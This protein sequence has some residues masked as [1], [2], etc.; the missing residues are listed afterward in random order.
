MSDDAEFSVAEQPDRGRYELTRSDELISYALYEREGD[1]VA[2]P[3]VET[4]PDLRGHGMADRLMEG[5]LADLRA[6]GE[7]V[8]PLCGWARR[9]VRDHPEHHDLLAD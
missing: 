9:Y 2:V 7:R 1:V 8:L 4:R 3:H 6:R 5:L